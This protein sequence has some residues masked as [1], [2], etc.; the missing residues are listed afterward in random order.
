MEA[1]LFV[2]IKSFRKRP[3]GKKTSECRWELFPERR[4]NGDRTG[5]ADKRSR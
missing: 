5:A 4:W 2:F 3:W 1:F